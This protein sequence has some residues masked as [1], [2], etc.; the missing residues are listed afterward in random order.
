MLYAATTRSD[1][2]GL[3]IWLVIPLVLVILGFTL[4]YKRKR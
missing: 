2:S 4:Y 3:P 1:D